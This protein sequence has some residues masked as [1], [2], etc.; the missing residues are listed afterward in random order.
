MSECSLRLMVWDRSAFLHDDPI[1][2]NY[3]MV[4]LIVFVQARTAQF[5]IFLRDSCLHLSDAAP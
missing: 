4:F 3:I 2:Y 5:V 1:I